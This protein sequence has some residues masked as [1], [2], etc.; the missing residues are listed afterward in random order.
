MGLSWGLGL[1]LTI[2]RNIILKVKDL[3]TAIFN[4]KDVKIKAS[5]EVPFHEEIQSDSQ[6]I[7]MLQRHLIFLVV[8]NQN[9]CN[10]GIMNM[11][12]SSTHLPQTM[13][14]SKGTKKE[15]KKLFFDAVKAFEEDIQ[16]L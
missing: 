8:K 14:H 2:E 1:S 5:D 13:N 15:V 6:G 4:N 9:L 11:K 16:T 10:S 7:D 3:N 12:L